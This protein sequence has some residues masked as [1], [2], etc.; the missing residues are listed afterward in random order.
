MSTSSTKTAS[1]VGQGNQ[2]RLLTP[3]EV[4]VFL[5]VPLRTTT[6][7]GRGALDRAG[8]ASVAMFATGLTTSNAGSKITATH[9]DARAAFLDRSLLVKR[10]PG[11]TAAAACA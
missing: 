8:I 11:N 9:R 1:K 7:G 6:A 5:G 3:Y 10:S 4:S 2:A